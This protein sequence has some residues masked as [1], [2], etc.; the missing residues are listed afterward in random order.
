[1]AVLDGA[2]HECVSRSGRVLPR[3]YADRVFRYHGLARLQ[4]HHAERTAIL[5]FYGL[6]HVLDTHILRS[7]AHSFPVKSVRAGTILAVN[8][9]PRPG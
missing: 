8:G 5:V 3:H 2:S 9:A 6:G 7:D 4:G 1:M